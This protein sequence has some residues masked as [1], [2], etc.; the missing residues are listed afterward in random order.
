[1][2]D[3]DKQPIFTFRMKTCFANNSISQVENFTLQTL[4]LLFF[5]FY[6]FTLSYIKQ[7]CIVDFRHWGLGI[8]LAKVQS[9]CKWN[10]AWMS[11]KSI[12]SE[13][14]CGCSFDRCKQKNIWM[15]GNQNLWAINKRVEEKKTSNLPGWSFGKL[16]I[17]VLS[18]LCTYI[19]LTF[20]GWQAG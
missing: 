10:E 20:T 4:L 5:C 13:F 16:L 8:F 14:W 11:L 18:N 15:N 3:T 6:L 7:W 2:E 17:S 19:L 9:D 12:G 1:M